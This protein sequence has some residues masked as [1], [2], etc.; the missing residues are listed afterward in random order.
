VPEGFKIA[1][2][3]VDIEIDQTALDSSIAAATAKIDAIKARAVEV[4]IDQGTVDKGIAVMMAKLNALQA[5]IGVGINSEELIQ[6]VAELDAVMAFFQ[7]RWNVQVEFD[8]AALAGFAALEAE[9]DAIKKNLVEAAAAMA[10][11]S[12]TGVG[13]NTGGFVAQWGNWAHWIIAGTAELLAVTLPAVVALGAATADAAQGVQLAYEH[14]IAL[15]DAAEATNT[16][17]GQTLGTLLGFKDAL[18]EAQ[19]A[20]NPK[21]YQALGGAIE[22]IHQQFASLSSVGL[23]VL[24]E[25]DDFVAHMQMDFQQGFGGTLHSLLSAMVPDLVEI[26]QIFGNL[27]HAILNFAGDMPGLAEVLLRLLDVFSRWILDLS[28]IPGWIITVVIA[29]EEL[30]RWGG[31][32][33]TVFARVGSALANIIPIAGS[34]AAG[35][36]ERL[37]GVFEV[38]VNGAAMFVGNLALMAERMG[39]TEEDA[40][41]FQ[42]TMASAGSGLG[43]F[44]DSLGSIAEGVPVWAAALGVLAVAGFAALAIWALRSKTA[45]EEWADSLNDALQK[46]SDLELVN[47]TASDLTLTSQKLASAQ[48]ELA[49]TL[50]KTTNAAGG[51]ESRFYDFNPVI[52]QQQGNVEALTKEHQYLVQELQNEYASIGYLESRYGTTYIGALAL[53]QQASVNLTVGL[54]QS[55]DAADLARL[56]ID[57]LIEGYKAMGQPANIVGQDMTALAIDSGEAS[58]E[59]SKL[60]TAWDDFMNDLTGGTSALGSLQSAITNLTSGTNTVTSILGDSGSVT[61]TVGQ[62]AKSLESYSATGSQAWQN[63][64]EVITSSAEPLID[65]LRTAGTLGATTGPQFVQAV[66]DMV[67]ELL[68]FA[69][70]STTAQQELMGLADQASGSTITSMTELTKWLGNTGAAGAASSLSNIIA[71]TTGNMANMSKDAQSLGTVLNNDIV[72]TMDAAEI[73]TSGLS[74]ITEKYTQDLENANTPAKTLYTDH[75]NLVKVLTQL[76]GSVTTAN[77]IIGTYTQSVNTNATAIET[78]KGKVSDLIGELAKVPPGVTTK[79]TVT[80]SGS[81]VASAVGGS[82][83]RHED[84]R[85]RRRGHNPG[86]GRAWRGYY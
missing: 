74:A 11:I 72:A 45:V 9:T 33:V 76:T 37:A 67:A 21:V 30:Y 79:V 40:N 28:E 24:T 8:P 23:D 41:I 22:L 44:A 75:Q 25:L 10:A 36:G 47:K 60:N 59:V 20:A 62:F 82:G 19:N 73:K 71:T 78:N 49:T 70:D 81:W 13:T 43:G 14:T 61:L 27:G 84:S 65:W 18:Q 16:M 63:F 50:T 66:K 42:R 15:W 80:G 68:P 53:A 64:D 7:K 57:D 29:M 48:S 31:L 3:Y 1:D 51:A 56:K 6:A 35:F 26:G 34:L 17:F 54:T 2:G 83:S 77:Q 52:Q 38:L 86:Y 58:S 4:G 55:S 85:V 39:S 69:A 32:A 5:R 46:T 12:F